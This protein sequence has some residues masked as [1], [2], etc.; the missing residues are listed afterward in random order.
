L[1]LSYPQNPT[2]NS[3]KRAKPTHHPKPKIIFRNCLNFS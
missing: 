1:R 3:L 2:H